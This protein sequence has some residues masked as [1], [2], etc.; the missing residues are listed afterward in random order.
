MVEYITR[1]EKKLLGMAYNSLRKKVAEALVTLHKKYKRPINISRE[2]LA[3]IA[4]T[5]TASMIRT[6]GEFKME[7]LIEIKDGAI[8]LLNEEKLENMAV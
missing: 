2:N 8:T 1:N 3:A 7:K 5:A 4:G 6:L